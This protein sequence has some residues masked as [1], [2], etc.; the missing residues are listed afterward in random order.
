MRLVDWAKLQGVHDLTAYRWWRDGQL[1]VPARQMPSGAILVDLAPERQT[2]AVIYARVSSHDQRSDLDR[3]VARVASWATQ[4]KIA[5]SEI[6]TEVGSAMNGRRVR[7]RRVLSDPTLSPIIVEHRDRLARF[8]VEYLESA[9]A[10]QGRRIVVVDDNEHNDDLV[11]DMIDVL[12]S[13]CARI[14]GRRGARNRA[15]RALTCAKNAG[16]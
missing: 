6:V 4:A 8:G 9:L 7:F 15:L 12:T 14:Y 13:F 5:V 10:A 1:P 2:R 16:V 3:Q 11:R